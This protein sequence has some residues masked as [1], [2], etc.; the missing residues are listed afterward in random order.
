LINTTNKTNSEMPTKLTTEKWVIKARAIHGDTYD[1]SQVNYKDAKTHVIVVC[2]VHGSW[3]CNPSN[4]VNTSLA[5]GC[6]S[7]GGSKPKTTEKFVS[8][9]LLVHGNVYNYSQVK[10][11]N[12]QTLVTIICDLHGPFQQTPTSHL[13]GSGCKEC[14][15]ASNFNNIRE[16]SLLLVKKRLLEKTGN[17]VSIIDES[18]RN[19]NAEANFICKI[20][21]QFRRL[22]SLSQYGT[23]V[24]IQCYQESGQANLLT[25]Q[26]AEKRILSMLLN[27]EVKIEPF[28]YKGKNNTTLV[29]TCPKH[30]AWTAAWEVVTKNHGIC[31]KCSYEASVPKR[32]ASIK[33]HHNASRDKRW[34]DYLTKFKKSH[35]DLYDY[36]KATFID[37]K[38]PIE[39]VCPMHGSFMQTPD[40][41]TKGGC[42]LC[43]DEELAGLY[44][45]RY[46]ELK[47]EMTT[48][49]ATL[50]LLKLEFGDVICFKVGITRTSLKRRFGAALGKGVKIEVIATRDATL[51]E[52]WRDEVRLLG[53]NHFEKIE[54]QDKNFVRE[55]RMSLTELVKNLPVNWK[56]LAH[57]TCTESYWL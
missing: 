51:I 39:I 38:A 16:K 20:H 11:L 7:C 52:V 47:P 55:A 6:P 12:S 35:G 25:Q 48:V 30:G 3:N 10:Y 40:S 26:T 24:C 18:F 9:A 54:I 27:S 32:T 43:A 33:K 5:R 21:G 8:D 34:F 56:N 15:T 23:N 22:V 53:S 44:K 41:H 19:I 4:H 37:A 36:S 14:A 13:S 28:E 46:F 45:E 50:Y 57:W 17:G 31:P 29:L 49:A 2:K 1:Y 42:R